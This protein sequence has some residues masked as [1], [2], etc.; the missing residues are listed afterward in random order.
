[1]RMLSEP[2]VTYI[3][4]CS[5]LDI[6]RVLVSKTTVDLSHNMHARCCLHAMLSTR[7]RHDWHSN[8]FVYTFL[9]VIIYTSSAYSV[10]K[11]RTRKLCLS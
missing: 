2:L 9:A 7:D 8:K 5:N 1:M 10:M 11:L 3:I 4:E 6:Y